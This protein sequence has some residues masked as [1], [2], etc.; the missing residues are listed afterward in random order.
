MGETHCQSHLLTCTPSGP[1][2]IA[3]T[4][5]WYPRAVIVTR[6]E[7][8]TGCEPFDL[9]ATKSI[10]NTSTGE[11]GETVIQREVNSSAVSI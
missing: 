7:I 6:P 4:T 9:L 10:A 3:L 8:E 2:Y 5:N 11:S 1:R